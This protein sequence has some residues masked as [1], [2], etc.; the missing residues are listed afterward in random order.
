MILPGMRPLVLQVPLVCS[1]RAEAIC[2]W[3][4]RGLITSAGDFG[5]LC[6]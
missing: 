3:T 2:M 5:E 6:H 1:R 4:R